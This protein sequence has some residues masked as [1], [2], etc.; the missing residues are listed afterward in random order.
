M[1]QV[2]IT[3]LISPVVLLIVGLMI[4]IY[5]TKHTKT[6]PSSSVPVGQTIAG[7]AWAQRAYEALQAQLE[8]E[9]KDHSRCDELLRRNGVDVPHD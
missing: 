5:K 7:D 6:S 8:D 1:V 9:C 3:S 2:I 4:D